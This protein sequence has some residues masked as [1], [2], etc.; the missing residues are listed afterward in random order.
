MYTLY[1]IKCS[2]NSLYTGIAKNLK[3]RLET[4]RQGTG[5]KYVRARL[6][7]SL[8][9]TETLTDRSSA[10]KR[11]IAIKKMTRNEKIKLIS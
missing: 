7:F 9:Y 6:P 3:K 10:T 4:H 5:S 8:M 11:E 2:D 1:I